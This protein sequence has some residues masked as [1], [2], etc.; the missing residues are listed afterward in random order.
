MTSMSDVCVQCHF[1]IC[2]DISR[3]MSYRLLQVHFMMQQLYMNAG[4]ACYVSV[5]NL[6]R[7]SGEDYA[8]SRSRVCSS[9]N[10]SQLHHLLIF[11]AIL[12]S[13]LILWS[14][15]FTANGRSFWSI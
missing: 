8:K 14:Y 11:T 12:T 4:E 10:F 1:Q 3:T 9:T 2:F 13:G 7:D 5:F 15:K 6:L